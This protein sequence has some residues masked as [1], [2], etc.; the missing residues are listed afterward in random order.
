MVNDVFQDFLDDTGRNT[1]SGWRC[2]LCGAID[3]PL[4][5]AH[6]VTPPRPVLGTSRR[7]WTKPKHVEPK[8]QVEL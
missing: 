6:R 4:I 3:D 1:F 8:V 2:L 5:A 7:R